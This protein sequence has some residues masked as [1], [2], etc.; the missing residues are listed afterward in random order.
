VSRDLKLSSQ[1]S[2]RQLE[3]LLCLIAGDTTAEIAG[4]LQLSPSSVKRYISLLFKGC[5]A[6]HR[7][8]LVQHWADRL[9][10]EPVL[11]AAE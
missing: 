4:Y 3:V 11:E 5:G 8:E 6:H 10:A 2:T 1:L 9:F 7:A